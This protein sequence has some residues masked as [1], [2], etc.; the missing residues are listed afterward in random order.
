MTVTVYLSTDAGAPVLSGQVGTV[1][2]ILDACLVNGYG[3]KAAA[4]WTKEFSATNVGV[5]RAPI[6]TRY[7]LQ[8]DD[9]SVNTTVVNAFV[10]GY[11][12]MSDEVTGTN[13]FPSTATLANGFLINKSDFT[14]TSTRAWM[15]VAHER[16]FYLFLYPGFSD[17]V[18]G[19][20]SSLTQNSS[21]FFGEIVSYVPVAD[22]YN[23]F[24]IS[25]MS[26]LIGTSHG[27]WGTSA[28]GNYG[29]R[30]FDGSIISHGFAKTTCN[31]GVI[32]SLQQ[33]YQRVH[34][35]PVSSELGLNIFEILEQTPV[36]SPDTKYSARGKMPGLFSTVVLAG[37]NERRTGPTATFNGTGNTAGR[38]FMP[39]VLPYL[40]GTLNTTPHA[41]IELTDN[42]Y[43]L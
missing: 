26:T 5:Y 13:P 27:T 38:Q 2:P 15:M 40:Y 17:S 32:C 31:G 33:Y 20:S 19:G 18:Q 21:F 42:W 7:Y 25:N 9:T 37:V 39:I 14:G 8:V 30:N 28:V 34:P 11:E 4:G 12:T 23:S 43:T 24:L 6:G 22:P 16:S 10:R 29:A 41:Y 3:S 36:S 1:I 35:D